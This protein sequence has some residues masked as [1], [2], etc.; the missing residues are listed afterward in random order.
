MVLGHSNCVGNGGGP[1]PHNMGWLWNVQ[2]P[3]LE[4][5]IKKYFNFKKLFFYVE[6]H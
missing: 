1:V 5:V 6:Y 3:G 4:K 2:I